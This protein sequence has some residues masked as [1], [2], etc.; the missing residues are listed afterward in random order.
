M[1]LINT[2]KR[3]IKEPPKADKEADGGWDVFEDENNACLKNYVPS[4]NPASLLDPANPANPAHD[5]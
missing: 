1:F 3:V 2:I 4:F 5:D